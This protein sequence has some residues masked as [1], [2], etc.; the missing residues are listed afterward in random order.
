MFPAERGGAQ[1]MESQ[2]KR[3]APAIRVLRQEA[4]LLQRMED[5]E[6]GRFAEV[7][8]GR[9]F[10]QGPGFAPGE[11]VDYLQPLAEGGKPVGILGFRNGHDAQ[12][13]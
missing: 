9:Q 13:F 3:V 6:D 12:R 2:S 1:G 5:P 11:A 7:E 10:G 8:R 4:E